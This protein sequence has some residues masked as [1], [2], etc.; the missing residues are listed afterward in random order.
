MVANSSTFRP[1]PPPGEGYWGYMFLLLHAVRHGTEALVY[2]NLPKE[3]AAFTCLAV[4]YRRIASG[5]PW[6]PC[7]KAV[8]MQLPPH[9]CRH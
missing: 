8:P 6:F 5:I 4:I 7:S 1:P 2:S 3:A 9:Q